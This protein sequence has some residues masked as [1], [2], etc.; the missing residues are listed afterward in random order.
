MSR[1]RTIWLVWP[2]L[3]GGLEPGAI[4]RI[5][6]S[7][8]WKPQAGSTTRGKAERRFQALLRGGNIYTTGVLLAK[9]E[10]IPQSR[11]AFERARDA[12]GY[13]R[14][15]RHE[16]LSVRL[17]ESAPELLPSDQTLRDLVL[18]LIASH[19]GHCRPFAPV[20]EDAQP[21]ETTIE[22]DGQRLSGSLGHRA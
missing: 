16:L 15:G 11:A 8:P 3:P 12:V 10:D 1:C 6:S 4:C 9:S 7:K 17:A 22:I 21:V 14:G 20:V 5:T 2:D 18:H 19:H 13:P